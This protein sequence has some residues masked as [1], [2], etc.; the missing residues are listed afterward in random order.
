MLLALAFFGLTITLVACDQ[1][2]AVNSTKT[3]QVMHVSAAEAHE[4]TKNQPE[5]VVLDIRTP[6]EFNSGHIKGAVNIDFKASSFATELQALDPAKN[7][8]VH[9]HSGGRSTSS[10][11][12]FKNLNFTNITHLDGGI[13]AWN[14]AE[15]PTTLH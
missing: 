4:L 13:K 12:T 8:L 3:G 14:K 10:L 2:T 1:N 9:C 11:K 7:Y 6:D 15:L 5:L